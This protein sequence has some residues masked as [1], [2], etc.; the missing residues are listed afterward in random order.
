METYTPSL[1]NQKNSDRFL[2][3]SKS[4]FARS[5]SKPADCVGEGC[6]TFHSIMVVWSAP[7]DVLLTPSPKKGE[8]ADPPSVSQSEA[9]GWRELC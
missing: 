1:G 6:C 5:P 8:L 9:G 4:C 3:F 2:L 7:L